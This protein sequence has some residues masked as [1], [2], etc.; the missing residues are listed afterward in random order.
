MTRELTPEEVEDL[1]AGYLSLFV[2][3]EAVRLI[4]RQDGEFCVHDGFV[5]PCKTV[6]ALRDAGRVSLDTQ[7]PK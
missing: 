3:V 6:R 2:A 5:W 4:H 7:E 1:K